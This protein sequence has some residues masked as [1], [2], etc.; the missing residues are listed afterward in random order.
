MDSH[1]PST[2]L[3][4]AAFNEEDF[5]EEKI[6]NCLAIDYPKDK[7]QILFITDGSSD[8]SPLGSP[9]GLAEGV[10]GGPRGG[11][12]GGAGGWRDG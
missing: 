9:D 5:I 7:F 2:T 6:Q 3:L 4:I 11:I 1:L 8:G 10:D 12:E